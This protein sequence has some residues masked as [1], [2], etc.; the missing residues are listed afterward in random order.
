M[1]VLCIPTCLSGL[2]IHV[3]F[4]IFSPWNASFRN[5]PESMV[6]DYITDVDIAEQIC[7]F[8]M[9]SCFFYCFQTLF[10]AY[11]SFFFN[12]SGCGS[13]VVYFA[14]SCL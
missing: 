7:K 8:V 14:L 12:M 3:W 1:H 9:L 13:L 6:S 11:K 2:F 10:L 5:C 4:I